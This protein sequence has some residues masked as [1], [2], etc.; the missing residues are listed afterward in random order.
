MTLNISIIYGSTR[1]GRLGIKFAKYLYKEFNKRG[2]NSNLIDPLELKL[3]PLVKRYADF[4]KGSA[5]K[6]L[7]QTHN[8]LTQSDA[9][10]IAVSYTHLTL[11]TT[12]YV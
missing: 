4:E 2:N 9:F 5:P 6:A 10:V 3:N 7:E 11:P 1:E 8:L 12:P